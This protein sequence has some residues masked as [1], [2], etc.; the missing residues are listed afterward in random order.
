MSVV[1]SG[2]LHHIR[3]KGA[4]GWT[5]AVLCTASGTVG[6][7]GS[8]DDAQPGDAMQLRGEWTEH[9]RY[10]RQFKIATVVEVRASVRGVEAWLQVLPGIGPRRAAA[11]VARYGEGVWDVLEKDPAQI[12]AV[13]GITLD[14]AQKIGAAYAARKHER[15]LMVWLRKLGLSDVQCV[16]AIEHFGASLLRGVIEQN[17]YRLVEVKGFGFKT[18]DAWALANGTPLESEWRLQAALVWLLE[19]GARNGHVYVPRA[20][21]IE[22]GAR[23]LVVDDVDLRKALHA[24]AAQENAPV[25]LAGPRGDRVYLRRLH[26]AEVWV[27]RF[28]R[29]ALVGNETTGEIR[30]LRP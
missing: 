25:V 21:L 1:L 16:R 30:D 15:A 9:A 26:Y 29:D 3:H 8:I 5:A 12:C 10:G 18:V 7:V 23:L 27:A 14:M 6:I 2:T 22:T 24:V 4:D 17:P 28:L 20:A 19:E 11:I 13:P